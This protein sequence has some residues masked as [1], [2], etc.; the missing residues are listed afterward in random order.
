MADQLLGLIPHTSPPSS[1]FHS[2]SCQQA[3]LGE[4][5]DLL[6]NATRYNLS[7][8]GADC[9]DDD[10]DDVDDDD[11]DDD[12]ES[13]FPDELNILEIAEDLKADIRNLFDLIPSIEC[14]AT[15]PRDERRFRP[16]LPLRK[17]FP[18]ITMQIS[19]GENLHWQA[20]SG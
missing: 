13:E 14:P 16:V 8:K 4:E 11:D 15:D 6:L 10:E 3:L 20:R 12:E 2:S 7:K 1:T 18:I 5:L 9:H 17:D 19:L